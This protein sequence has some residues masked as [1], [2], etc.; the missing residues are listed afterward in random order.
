IVIADNLKAL[1]A[2]FMLDGSPMK[3]EMLKFSM[4]QNFNTLEKNDSNKIIAEFFSENF[5]GN[6]LQSVP[7]Q[8]H[9]FSIS[10]PADNDIQRY[11]KSRENY[12]P[13]P[14]FDSSFNMYFSHSIDV[15]LET[16]AKLVQGF[17]QFR[18]EFFGVTI[19]HTLPVG[20]LEELKEYLFNTNIAPEEERKR[21]NLLNEEIQNLLAHQVG[22]LEGY[23]TSATEGS[24]GLLQ[25]LD[26]ESVEQEV[27]KKNMHS[28][29]I[30]MAKIIPAFGSKKILETLK[31]NYKK[32]ISDPYY[33][34]KKF[35]RAHFL[36]GY[37][38][39]S[40]GRLHEE[41]R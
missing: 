20:S 26:P 31:E 3:A 1:S 38:K 25:S 29:G 14:A 8:K 34:E 5:L 6:S 11:S 30:D 23:K 32:Y 27:Q 36:K 17:L 7:E 21:I 35:F 37:Q 24:R 12:K 18:Q 22:L 4:M 40:A 2:K 33:I 41:L 19:Y 10:T 9:E 16:F 39:R 28:G 13:Q 15:L